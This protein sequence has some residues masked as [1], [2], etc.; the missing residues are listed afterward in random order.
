MSDG[1]EERQ[2]RLKRKELERPEE[3]YDRLDPYEPDGSEPERS[4]S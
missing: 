1:L 4:D 2:E 3:R